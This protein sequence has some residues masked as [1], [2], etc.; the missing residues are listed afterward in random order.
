LVKFALFLLLIALVARWFFRGRGRHG[1]PNSP[2]PEQ[3]PYT[4]P[5]EQSR[6]GPEQPPYTGGTEQL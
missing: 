6:P 5:G 4:S 1:P 3:P 2:G